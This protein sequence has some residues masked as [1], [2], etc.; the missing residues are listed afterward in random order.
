MVVAAWRS[1]DARAVGEAVS[2]KSGV[3]N[4]VI[5]LTFRRYVRS[6]P[7]FDMN[8]K[9]GFPYQFNHRFVT[10]ETGYRYHRVYLLQQFVRRAWACMDEFDQYCRSLT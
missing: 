6:G 1:Q 9:Y 10:M 3:H 8:K 4:L 7:G 5:G 2:A